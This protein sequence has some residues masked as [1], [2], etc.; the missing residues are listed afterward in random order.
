MKDKFFEKL[1]KVH[2]GLV[3]SI[4]G[5]MAKQGVLSAGE[6]QESLQKA[7][8]DNAS[9]EYV[10]EYKKAKGKGSNQ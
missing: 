8:K 2:H 10:A 6:L 4:D 1:D 7:I 5:T 9:N 3:G